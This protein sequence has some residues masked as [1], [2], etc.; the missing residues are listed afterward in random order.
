MQQNYME[1]FIMSIIAIT[2]ANNNNTN[3]SQTKI[4]NNKITGQFYAIQEQEIKDM[5]REG[6]VTTT[7]YVH[8]ILRFLNPYFDKTLHINVP[9]FL[10]KWGIAKSS[11]HKAIAKLAE[12]KIITLGSDDE[13]VYVQRSDQKNLSQNEMSQER[14]GLSNQ[15]KNSSEQKTVTQIQNDLSQMLDKPIY[16]DPAREDNKTKNTK[17]TNKTAVDS[18]AHT[19]SMYPE[20][21]SSSSKKDFLQKSDKK[22]NQQEKADERPRSGNPTLGTREE[23]N[24]STTPLVKSTTHNS[25]PNQPPTL[26]GGQSSQACSTIESKKSDKKRQEGDSKDPSASCPLPS[27]FKSTYDR[28]LEYEKRL[29]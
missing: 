7:G 26:K 15:E 19:R 3:F 23:G 22:S 21:N 17:K 8:Q 29:D 20:Q 4:R 13:I 16:K 11:F 1:F 25:T 9:K 6:F 28:S 5:R 12:L 10:K 27:A 2:S 18:D 24:F 14:N